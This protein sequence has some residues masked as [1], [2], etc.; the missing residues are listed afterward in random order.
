MP[1]NWRLARPTLAHIVA[2]LSVAAL[3][4]GCGSDDA[5]FSTPAATFT[6]YREAL[7]DG[8]PVAT[9]ACLSTG[10]RQIEFEGDVNR[11]AQHLL[12]A[13]ATLRREVSRLEINQETEINQR[14]GFLQFDPTTVASGRGPFYYFLRESDGWKITTHL[15][16]TFRVEL[17]TAIERGEFTLPATRR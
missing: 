16:S 5:R 13:G 10:Y 12:Q 17:E 14:L 2:G 3:L 1:L 7:N 6:T 9:W 8:D 4:L 11:W 15:D